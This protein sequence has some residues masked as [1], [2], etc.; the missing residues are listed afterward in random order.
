MSDHYKYY[1]NDESLGSSCAELEDDYNALEISVYYSKGGMNY[2]NGKNEEGGAYVSVKGVKVSNE[3]YFRSV[4]FMFGGGSPA[5]GKVLVKE[6]K[7]NNRKSIKALSEKVFAY[8]D[9]NKADVLEVYKAGRGDLMINLVA[10]SMIEMK[11]V[12]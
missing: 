7:R 12:A 4:S 6:M 9:A 2:W 10:A 1:I 11:E 5:D 3:G 8:M